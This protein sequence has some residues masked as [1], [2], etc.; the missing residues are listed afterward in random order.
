MT[1][2]ASFAFLTLLLVAP[3]GAAQLTAGPLIGGTSDTTSRVWVRADGPC[4][5]QVRTR[6]ASSTNGPWANVAPARTRDDADNTAIVDLAD[7][8]PATDYAYE[9][10]LD[11]ALVPG[12]PWA[13]RTLPA[14]GTGKVTVAFGSC[15]HMGRQPEQPIFDVIAAAKP[16]AFV[17]LGDN[18]YFDADDCD[19]EA[20]LWA[21]ARAQRENPGLKAL[22]AST[23]T[24]AQWDDHDY[25]PNDS[26][27]TFELKRVTRKIFV[28]Y[29]PN[30]GAGEDGEG[31]YTRA[32]LGPIDLFL[33]DDRWFRDPN[34]EPNSAD[35]TILGPRQRAWLLEGLAA[36]K[37]PLKVVATAGQ[38][39]ARYHTF[40]SWQ[41]ARD[42][43]ELIVDAI[44]DRGIK[45]VMFISGDRHLSEVI[46]WPAE[47]AGYPLWDITSS[48]LAN[49]SFAKGG[50]VPNADRQFIYGD[51]NS[52]GV[53]EVD[54]EA[55]K[56]RFEL[57]D[58]TGKLLW[59]AEPTDLLAP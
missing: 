51:G 19:D 10:R 42:E 48:P 2:C 45:G 47:R 30:V 6:P 55:K 14:A 4:A 52:Y 1:R 26:D 21:R 15:I 22:L 11:G 41:L 28:S 31:I 24:F 32:S 36:S 49:R 18:H 57:R 12:G 35:K 33:L 37:A 17:F 9:V 7:L 5:V 27:R 59:S 44:R 40:E 29:W 20:A 43:R 34:R 46:R 50:D 3:A 23:P 25:G 56:V 38:F 13:F 53:I 39:L 8:A 16:S 58:Q 54:A